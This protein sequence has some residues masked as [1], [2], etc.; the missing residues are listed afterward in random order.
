MIYET[1]NGMTV[2][3]FGGTI[4]VG[5]AYDEQ[6]N[7]A[8][9]VLCSESTKREIG[10]NIPVKEGQPIGDKPN[11]IIFEFRCKESIDIVIKHLK[12]AKETIKK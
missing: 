5:V 10:E 1:E 9:M 8:Y 3:E 12:I 4:G 6:T 2:V 11:Q 7:I